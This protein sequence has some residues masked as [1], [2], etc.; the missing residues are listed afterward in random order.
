[1]SIHLRDSRNVE[2]DTA[3]TVWIGLHGSPVYPQPPRL[4][5]AASLTVANCQG[6][7]DP[8]PVWY[9]DTADPEVWN[10]APGSPY[11]S[12]LYVDP[13]TGT[14][15]CSG[16]N[17]LDLLDGHMYEIIVLDPNAPYCRGT[18]SPY[19]VGCEKAYF[20]MTGDPG[21]GSATVDIR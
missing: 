4:N 10:E 2:V 11:P 14:G 9:R 13:V 5:P 6:S 17:R 7:R 15:H 21:A 8:L 12:D 20:R 3:A 1:V 18:V 16:A 19:I